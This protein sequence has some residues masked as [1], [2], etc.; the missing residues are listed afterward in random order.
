MDAHGVDIFDKADGDQPVVGV[1]HDLQFEF[2]PTDDRFFHQNLPDPAGG[3]APGGDDPQFFQVVDQAA[4][5]AA[6]GVGRANHH[7]IAQFRRD[8]FGILDRVHGG[9]FRHF[10]AEQIHLLLEFDPVLAALD[11]AQIDADHLD[12]VFLQNAQSGQFGGEVEG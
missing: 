3:D 4:A 7:R 11:G 2:L 10:D 1:A 12:A 5:G 8:F 9:A 6:H